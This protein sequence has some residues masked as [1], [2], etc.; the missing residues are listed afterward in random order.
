MHAFRHTMI[1]DLILA[2]GEKG[3]AVASKQA[4]HSSIAI[5][6]QYLSILEEDAVEA[7]AAMKKRRAR[8]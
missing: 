2:D 5:T 6:S 8:N 1:S 7:L 4:G 3:L